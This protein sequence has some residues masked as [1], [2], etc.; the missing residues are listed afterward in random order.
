MCGC[1]TV[2]QDSESAELV[3]KTRSLLGVSCAAAAWHGRWHTW[4]QFW[5][6]R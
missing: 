6:S 4:W 2:V 1:V 5:V 3:A